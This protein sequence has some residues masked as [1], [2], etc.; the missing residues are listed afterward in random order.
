MRLRALLQVQRGGT[1]LRGVLDRMHLALQRGI[2]LALAQAGHAHQVAALQQA[3]GSKQVFDVLIAH[4]ADQHHQRA[5][6]LAQ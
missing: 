3:H 1:G 2:Q 4:V 6:T 5:S